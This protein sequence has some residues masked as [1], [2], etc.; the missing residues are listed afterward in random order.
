[1]AMYTRLSE[2]LQ[3]IILANSTNAF[4]V[5]DGKITQATENEKLSFE[6]CP[7]QSR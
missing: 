4:T 2:M 7:S 1:M 3:D 6:Q 5:N